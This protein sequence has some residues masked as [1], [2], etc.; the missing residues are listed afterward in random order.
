MAV[1]CLIAFEFAQLF[2]YDQIVYNCARNGAI[3]LSVPPTLRG[4]SPFADATQAA[5][6]DW[7]T[8]IGALTVTVND[9]APLTQASVTCEWTYT[10][11]FLRRWVTFPNLVLRRTVRVQVAPPTSS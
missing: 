7:P 10:S 8:G 5:R 6:A 3:Y 2:Y 9:G 4:E 11:P 1:M